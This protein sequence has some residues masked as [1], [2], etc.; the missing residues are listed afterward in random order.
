MNISKVALAVSTTTLLSGLL[1]GCGGDS[2]SGKIG[3]NPPEPP[4]VVTPPAEGKS[5][6]VTVIDGYLEGATVWLDK[7]MNQNF[8]PDGDEPRA[9]TD[10]KG[11]LT[12]KDL[13]G[14]S[15]DEYV[16][17]AKATAGKTIDHDNGKPVAKTFF[18]TAPVTEVDGTLRTSPAPELHASVISPLT[19]LVEMKL[20]QPSLLASEASIVVA[21]Q[22]VATQLGIAQENADIVLSDFKKLDSVDASKAEQGAASLIAAGAMPSTVEQLLKQ[23]DKTLAFSDTINSAVKDAADDEIVVAD[24]AEGIRIVKTTDS[25]DDGVIDALDA[26]PEDASEWYDS[27]GDGEGNEVDTDDDDDG[28]DDGDDDFPLEHDENADADDDDIGDNE[29]TD[30]DN[31]GVEDGDDAFPFDSDEDTDTDDDGIGDNADT[32]DDN[33]GVDDGDDDFPLD[34]DDDGVDNITDDDD[35]GDGYKD[36]EDNDPLEPLQIPTS[37]NVCLDSL[38]DYP[39]GEGIE[40]MT[41]SRSYHITRINV[42]SEAA[43]EFT[44]TEQYVGQRNGLPDGSMAG[45]NLDVTQVITG[46]KGANL[47]KWNPGFELMYTDSDSQQYLGTEDVFRRWWSVITATNIP[48]DLPLNVET[49]GWIE[50]LDQYSPEVPAR[51]ENVMSVYLGKEIIETILGYREVC[52]VQSKNELELVDQT[53]V[54]EESKR[55]SVYAV[56]DSK[57]YLDKGRVPLRVEKDY[58]EYNLEDKSTPTWGYSDYVQELTGMIQDDQLYGVNPVAGLV[59]EGQPVTME[60]CLAEL[61]DAE[62]EPKQNDTLLYDMYRFN[63]EKELQQDASYEYVLL[64]DSDID[65]H[66]QSGLSESRIT[67]SFY[68]GSFFIERYFSNGNGAMVGF[69]GREN[70]S[71]QIA[72]GN[73]ITASEQLSLDGSYFIPEVHHYAGKLLSAPEQQASFKQV[74]SV[75]FAGSEQVLDFTTTEDVPACKYYS[76][77]ETTYYQPDGSPLL[78]EENKPVVEFIDETVW[79]DNMGVINRDRT[80]DGWDAEHWYR[81]GVKVQD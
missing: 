44:R 4:P 29:D 15:L 67:G 17:V 36:G 18:L 42:G 39:E 6:T 61:P 73:E 68:D 78:D 8:S 33:D 31:D 38:P 21:I 24:E 66:G 74:Q 65:W 51:H 11:M 48:V 76:R 12:F 16:L 1:S 40:D 3:P 32:D 64:V 9:V 23:A 69:E 28:V 77:L 81:S 52:V 79:R 34:T 30:D 22:Q 2:G 54:P 10:S 13:G 25:D 37:L 59:P 56:H 41:D 62:Y 80:S 60:Q 50:R 46:A 72:W 63:T 20:R 70:G 5:L 57:S 58:K 55:S 49:V 43:V 71:D 53:S 75:V 26:F 45:R 27:D 7:K 47:D 14:L 35:D 19:T